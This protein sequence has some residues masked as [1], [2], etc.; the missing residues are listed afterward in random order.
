MFAL[1]CDVVS[2]AMD[3]SIFYFRVLCYKSFSTIIYVKKSRTLGL[4]TLYNG[5]FICVF[6]RVTFLWGG[7]EQRMM[8]NSYDMM[9]ESH[10]RVI[11]GPTTWPHTKGSCITMS[12]RANLAQ[13]WTNA[14]WRDSNACRWAPCDVEI[15]PHIGPWIHTQ[16]AQGTLVYLRG[17]GL[18][19]I[20][21]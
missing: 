14:P 10:I 20:N 5:S 6:P 8:G 16:T 4:L 13:Q 3:F 15:L 11:S 7:N 17:E 9:V 12:E 19:H 1:Y 21:Y 2:N 18:R